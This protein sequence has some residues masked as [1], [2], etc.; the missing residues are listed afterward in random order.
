MRALITGASG[1]VGYQ[2]A[3]TMTARGWRMVYL[4]RNPVDEIS[5]ELGEDPDLP[6]ADVLIHCALDHVPGLYRGGEGSDPAGFRRRNLMGTLTLARAAQRAGVPRIAFLSSRAIYGSQPPG[7]RLTEETSPNPDTL[8]GAMKLE[9]EHALNQMSTPDFTAVSVR[10][11]GVYGEPP[12]G[13]NH[14]W[15]SL[16]EDFVAGLAIKPRSGTEIHGI[17]LAYAVMRLVDAPPGAYN[18]SDIILDRADLLSRFAALTG[19]AGKL[20]P[21]ADAEALNVM[22]TEKL[23]ALGWTPGGMS[24]FD[25]TLP[26]L[27]QRQYAVQESA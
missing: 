27:V 12:S 4:G 21:R 5:W 26:Q 7:Q 2:I 18:V 13:R 17:D 1:L 9:T 16:F 14:K 19:I 25:Q 10:A 20:P 15:H 23:R 24:R 22:L 3:R 6:P 8:Y 11:T